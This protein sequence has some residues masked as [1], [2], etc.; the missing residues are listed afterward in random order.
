MAGLRDDEV[1]DPPIKAALGLS[2]ELTL[3]EALVAAN[4][5]M[6]LP[7]EGTLPS[8]AA[9]LESALG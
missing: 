9:A 8:Q 5:L 3:R 2:S 1:L 7:N 6:G 4:E